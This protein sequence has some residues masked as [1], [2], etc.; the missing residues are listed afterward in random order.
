MLAPPALAAE[1]GIAVQTLAA[2]VE[3]M[4]GATDVPSVLIEL[5]YMS[6]RRDLKNLTSADWQAHTAEQ[7]AHAV[8]DFFAKRL[9]GASVGAR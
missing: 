2:P 4:P 6:T 9:V 7:M 1:P 8:D 5:G 3:S